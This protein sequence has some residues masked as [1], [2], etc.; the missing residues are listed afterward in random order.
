MNATKHRFKA[1]W[2][3]LQHFDESGEWLPDRDEY[4]VAYFETFDEAQAAAIK[5]SKRAAQA[6]W[7]RIAEQELIDSEDETGTPWR[8][9]E[10]QR[11]WTGDY[12]GVED[13]N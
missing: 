1:E 2:I 5:N 9:W 10:T 11:A 13:S 6:E 7:I 4:G 12:D 8:R 3:Q